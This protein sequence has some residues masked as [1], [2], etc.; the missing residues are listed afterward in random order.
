MSIKSS[1]RNIFVTYDWR[2]RGQQKHGY[3]QKASLFLNMVSKQL[4]RFIAVWP[5]RY[6]PANPVPYLPT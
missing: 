3:Q 6:P 5:L 2:Y 4:T 1:N